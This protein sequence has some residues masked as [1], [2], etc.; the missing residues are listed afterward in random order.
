MV[1]PTPAQIS[2]MTPPANDYSDYK[3]GDGRANLLSRI[4]LAR[5]LTPFVDGNGVFVQ[6]P[7]A[8]PPAAATLYTQFPL[9]TN[10]QLRYYYAIYDRQQFAMDI[11][12]RLIQSTGAASLDRIKTK[13]A[14]L[15]EYS[16]VRDSVN[17]RS[18]WS[19]T[20]MTTT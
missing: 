5:K 17:S 9:A 19:I 7:R 14:T 20:S 3:L 18:I 2:D 15:A 12:V 13:T 10:P 16:A 1:T 4:D 11:L 6:P 8:A